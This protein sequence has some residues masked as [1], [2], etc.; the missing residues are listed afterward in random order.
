MR[1]FIE[2]GNDSCFAVQKNILVIPELLFRILLFPAVFLYL[3]VIHNQA[4]L[5]YTALLCYYFLL[6]AILHN[7]I[8]A[9]TVK[10]FVDAGIPTSTVLDCAVG[11]VMDQVRARRLSQ[12]ELFFSL[13]IRCTFLHVPCV[14]LYAGLLGIADKSNASGGERVCDICCMGYADEYGTYFQCKER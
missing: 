10:V 13:L 9:A 2:L 11:A 8:S 3:V 5:I 7:C 14:I 1:D 4:S 12:K 6:S